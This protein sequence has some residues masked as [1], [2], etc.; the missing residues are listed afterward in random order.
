M[1][2]KP[3]I[4]ITSENETHALVHADD[5][6][7]RE[8]RDKYAFRP[9]GYQFDKRYK[10]GIWSGWIRIFNEQNKT[11]PKGLVPD[12][13]DWSQA[14][15][16]NVQI[17][18]DGFRHFAEKIEYDIEG[19]N[20]PF[21][22]H[23][24]QVEAV[25]RCLDKKRQIILSPTAS[26][27]SFIIYMLCQALISSNRI[28]IVV[29]TVGLVT[30]LFSD[31]NN[32]SVKNGFS[33]DEL[34]HTIYSGQEKYSDKPITISTWQSIF[35]M[36]TS[37]FRSFDAVVADECLHPESKITTID[38]SKFIKDI[39]S[40]EFVLT[41]NEVTGEL[42]YKEVVEVFKNN[43]FA[44]QMFEIE[45]EDGRKL[46]ITGNHKVLTQ[47]G[48]VRADELEECDLINDISL[49]YMDFGNV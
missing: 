41:T 35:K 43:S 37:F 2:K 20:L 15:N 7:L 5:G 45:C 19:M 39:K 14:Q 11:L 17:T 31:F 24:Y 38:G 4:V 26:G 10:A 21:A 33:V 9:E 25:T 28:L 30:Q 1:P 18:P 46:K 29:P 34:V 3:D 44:E 49:N 8:I 42:E 36:P 22:P 23:D 12:L 6:I 16:Y 27:K 13:I 48:W 47:R 40:G 32:Y